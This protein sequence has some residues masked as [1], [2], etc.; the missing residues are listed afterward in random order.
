MRVDRAWQYL[1]QRSRWSPLHQYRWRATRADIRATP[2]SKRDLRRSGE[3]LPFHW[4][5][6]DT[7][8]HLLELPGV[9]VP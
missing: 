4:R 2:S 6:D 5:L 8:R 3:E 1:E 7:I 9:Q